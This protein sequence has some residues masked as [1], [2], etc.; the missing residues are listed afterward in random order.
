VNWQL[1]RTDGA[2]VNG[3]LTGS[4]IGGFAGLGVS[5][6]GGGFTASKPIMADGA[7]RFEQLPA[8]VY[9][10]E[11][12]GIGVVA[13][14]IVL[15][16]VSALDLPPIDI[17]SYRRGV[18]EGTISDLQGNPWVGITVRL[19]QQQKEMSCTS[20]NSVGHYRFEQLLP[21][22]YAI[23]TVDPPARSSAI[24]VDGTAI[25]TVD[26][27]IP[28]TSVAPKT[29]GHYLLFGRPGVLGGKANYR[30]ARKYMINAAY[31]VG[32]D[33][34]EAAYAEKVTIIGD[35]NMVSQEAEERLRQAGCIVGRVAGDTYA[36]VEQLSAL[37]E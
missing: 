19:K 23:E 8:G 13:R 20:T 6:S 25:K 34:G 18:I 15:D 27:R 12:E 10:L 37:S 3:I 16:G 32:F 35:V 28:N 26:L 9:Q 31:A 2:P 5:L 7:F 4:I 29:I 11:V 33:V 21:G 36:I 17:S 24:L 30:A 22:A 1:C 14:E